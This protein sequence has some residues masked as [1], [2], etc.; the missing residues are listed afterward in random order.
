MDSTENIALEEKEIA[1]LFF[2]NEDPGFIESAFYAILDDF[3]I[4]RTE[5]LSAIKSPKKVYFYYYPAI[6]KK[7]GYTYFVWLDYSV[8]G[9]ARNAYKLRT[10]KE[11]Q[12]DHKPVY[13]PK[14]ASGEYSKRSFSRARPEELE[15]VLEVEDRLKELRELQKQVVAA[16]KII[17]KSAQLMVRTKEYL[18]QLDAN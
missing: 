12:L 17:R 10:G 15:L 16:K 9:R 3:I 18:N 5:A 2:S 11:S 4:R 14:G 8:V 7:R 6:S 13:V 1:E